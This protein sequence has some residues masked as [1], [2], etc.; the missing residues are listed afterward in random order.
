MSLKQYIVAN[1]DCTCVLSIFS[2]DTTK[3]DPYSLLSGVRSHFKHGQ[4]ASWI[5]LWNKTIPHVYVIAKTT[6]SL[7]GRPKSWHPLPHKFQVFQVF[8]NWLVISY[9]EHRSI[10]KGISKNIVNFPS[11][12]DA[13]VYND[14]L[15]YLY[16]DAAKTELGR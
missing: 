3:F 9:V 6:L 7:Q 2:R 12:M 11:K 4:H 10:W 15:S 14:M 5:N 16:S 8:S 1:A 13:K